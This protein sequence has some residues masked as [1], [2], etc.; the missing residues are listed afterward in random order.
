MDRLRKFNKKSIKKPTDLKEPEVYEDLDT[1][2]IN[3]PWQSEGFPNTSFAWKEH[4]T[5]DVDGSSEFVPK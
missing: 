1:S 4:C 5:W 3:H 2:K